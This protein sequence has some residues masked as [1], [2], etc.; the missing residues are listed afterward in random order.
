MDYLKT[1]VIH[2]DIRHSAFK[3]NCDSLLEMN[4][5]ASG[6]GAG[7]IINTEMGLSGYS[8]QSREELSGLTINENSE[9]INSFSD[10]SARHG[11]YICLGAAYKSKVSGLIYN[12]ALV[13]GPSGEIVLRYDKINSESKWACR[14][15]AGQNNVFDTPWGKIGVLICADSYFSLLCRATL[16]RGAQMI[17]VA[18]NW[19]CVGID[20]VDIWRARALENDVWLLAANRTGKDRTMDLTGA[21][22]CA[23]DNRGN[24]LFKEKNSEPEIFYTDIPLHN[25][26]I[27]TGKNV[28]ESRRPAEYS[29]I[30][31][32]FRGIE[33]F[34]THCSLPAFGD[35]K[36]CAYSSVPGKK[37]IED[38]GRDVENSECDTLL[39]FPEGKHDTGGYLELAAKEKCMICF[40][41]S[42]NGR[43][44]LI[45]KK[46]FLSIDPSEPVILCGPAKLAFPEKDEIFHPERFIHFSKKGCDLCVISGDEAEE[47]IRFLTKIRTL[48]RTA[49][50]AA[51]N[52]FS[53]VCLP[54]RGHERWVESPDTNNGSSQ[55]TFNTALSREKRFYH[56]YDYELLLKQ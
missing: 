4:R 26:K 29:N 35:L 36:V 5:E 34:T 53:T 28:A 23:F 22:S 27:I 48:E 16:L 17:L 33:D 44:R 24:F 2:P 50:A 51:F 41:D 32:D 47:N 43:L 21:Y 20:P 12:S 56:D 45:H 37:E 8:F 6:N 9:I 52:G 49:V 55:L 19:P 14:G 38:I 42:K 30:Y 40:R 11:N 3:E 31:L 54:P 7:I 39:V 15:Y 46:E 1:A 18:A 25:G 10:I 13:C